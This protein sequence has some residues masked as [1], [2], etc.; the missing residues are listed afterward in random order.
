MNS[1]Q[2]G[3]LMTTIVCS[4][5]YKQFAGV[6]KFLEVSRRKEY[7]HRDYKAGWNYTD[8]ASSS[9]PLP[10]DR[11]SVPTSRRA[12]R[13]QVATAASYTWITKLMRL[14]LI[15]SLRDPCSLAPLGLFY[16]ETVLCSSTY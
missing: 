11:E 8:W 12:A 14:N 7:V 1:G 13:L 5:K 9:E 4:Q 3:K 15:H 10:R 16:S 2:L 6:I